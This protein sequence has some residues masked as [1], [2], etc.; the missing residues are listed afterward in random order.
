M[1]SSFDD[2]YLEAKE[3]IDKDPKYILPE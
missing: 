1:P 2:A 3:E